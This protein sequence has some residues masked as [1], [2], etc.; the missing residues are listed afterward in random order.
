MDIDHLEILPVDSNPDSLEIRIVI[1]DIDEIIP[2]GDCHRLRIRSVYEGNK[3]R[4]D[5]TVTFHQDEIT[6]RTYIELSNINPHLDD[7]EISH[8]VAFIDDFIMWGNCEFI[9][10]IAGI[11]APLAAGLI[12]DPLDSA[13][14]G[15]LCLSCDAGCPEDSTCNE[16][17]NQCVWNGEDRCVPIP[18][19]MEAQINLPI[20]LSDFNPTMQNPLHLLVHLANYSD[21]ENDGLSLG[22]QG[23]FFAEHDL[24]VPDAEPP[25]LDRIPKSTELITDL[26]RVGN[27]FQ[28]GIAIHE[29]LLNLA[30]W[31]VYQSGAMCVAIGTSTVEQLTSSTLAILVTSLADLTEGQNVPLFVRLR[32]TMPP[33]MVL[34]TGEVAGGDPPTII[35]PLF[36]IEVSEMLI[37]FYVYIEERFA[38]VFVLDAD[39]SIPLALAPADDGSGITI[40]LGDFTEAF[41]RLDVIDAEL[42][43]EGDAARIADV[44]PGILGAMI[45]SFAG[46]LSEPIAIPPIAGLRLVLDGDSFTSIEGNTMMAIF[47]NL[48][49]GDEGKG[50]WYETSMTS[51]PQAIAEV[52][53][54]DSP[55]PQDI[56]TFEALRD[57]GSFADTD[58]IR[59]EL[60]LGLETLD[61]LDGPREYTY[62]IDGGLWHFYRETDTLTLRAPEFLLEGWHTVEV[63]SRVPGEHYSMS[64]PSPPIDILVDLASPHLELRREDDSLI[65]V[66]AWDSMWDA[67]ELTMRYRLDG[68]YWSLEMP[69][70]A[71]ALPAV[72]ERDVIELEVEVTD[73]AGRRSLVTRTFAVHGRTT[74]TATGGCECAVG[75]TGLSTVPWLWIGFA[76]FFMFLHRKP[77]VKNRR[78]SKGL[79][80]AG[81]FGAVLLMTLWTACSDDPPVGGAGG[82][83]GGGEGCEAHDECADEELCMAGECVENACEDDDFCPPGMV[84]VDEICV[85]RTSCTDDSQCEPG[86]FCIDDDD[87]GNSEC[88]RMPCEDHGDCGAISCGGG[89]LPYCVD[90]SCLCEIPCEEGCGDDAYCCNATSRCLDLPTACV[91]LSC[92]PGYAPAV[93]SPASGDSDS[94]EVTGPDCQ[95]EELPPLPLGDVGSYLSADADAAGTIYVSAFNRTYEDLMLGIPNGSDELVWQFVDGV[96][97]DGAVTG[98]VDGPRRGISEGG[99]RVGRYSSIAVTDDGT[100]HIVY[101]SRSTRD[102]RYARSVGG[103]GDADYQWELMTVDD[104]N[105]SGYYNSITLSAEGVP[106]IAYMVQRVEGDP[107]VWTSQVRYA[108]AD[109]A[110]PTAWTIEVIASAV[111]DQACGGSCGGSLRCHEETNRCERT[112]RD[113]SCNPECDETS[114]FEGEETN[115]CGHVVPGTGLT[116]LFEG[117]GL[118]THS[119]RFTSDDVGVV[120]YDHTRGNL[121]WSASVEGTFA[122][123]AAELLAGELPD[124]EEDE[125]DEPEDTGDMGWYNALLIDADDN[126]HITYVNATFDELLYMNLTEGV[127]EVI[128]SGLRGTADALQSILVGD[129]SSLVITSEGVLQ[130]AYMDASRHHTVTSQR[131]PDIGWMVPTSEMGGEEPYDGAFGWYLDQ[132]VVGD[133]VVLVSYRINV[134]EGIRDAVVRRLR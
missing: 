112:T 27:P 85:V 20:V 51:M 117:I 60:V 83:G 10:G 47:L 94:C 19:G 26:N 7:I 17:N 34:G 68:G 11:A 98:S 62:R 105:H 122:E 16:D 110:S 113:S 43:D 21:A 74:E 86:F 41:S 91:G 12:S 13:V 2:L 3:F 58:M 106:G 78:R 70:S 82:G 131:D 76:S 32:P 121:W 80:S 77:R 71:I 108:W 107:G 125:D 101:F 25:P 109:A 23:G 119:D 114:C 63:R 48:A 18:L 104:T 30:L 46:A 35:D 9:V 1:K 54:L 56:A 64:L 67:H 8:D 66:E 52:L 99:N 22:M 129:D 24:C 88:L 15:A 128:D 126:V 84:C 31:A 72:Y 120:W 40:L 28:I 33:I 103:G 90:D 118:F 29:H 53:L 95:C 134:R 69:V 116:Y 111:N 65:E 75:G 59:T 124:D 130:V 50:D 100:I 55:S 89:Q 36:T 123:V 38:R 96:P 92:D 79:S 14:A 132:V 81:I 133:T 5:L 49:A 102:L 39:I 45:P 61:H 73:P 57:R 42:L 37:E 115:T 87:D 93:T 4:I 6:E 97:E 44:L 127:V